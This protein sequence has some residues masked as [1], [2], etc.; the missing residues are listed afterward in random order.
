[1]DSKYP[2]GHSNTYR[3]FRY[4]AEKSNKSLKSREYAAGE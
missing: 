3:Y 2:K 4:E 1:M